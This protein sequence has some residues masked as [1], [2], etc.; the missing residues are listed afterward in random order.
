MLWSGVTSTLKISPGQVKLQDAVYTGDFATFLEVTSTYG[1]THT[2]SGMTLPSP[3]P[4][5]PPPLPPQP[6]HGTFSRL[7][8]VPSSPL[9]VRPHPAGNL[10]FDFHHLS[11]T[12]PVLDFI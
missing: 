1:S 5:V 6:R 12:L 4:Q 8:K 2:C 9:R 11:F 3:I 10:C 7:Q